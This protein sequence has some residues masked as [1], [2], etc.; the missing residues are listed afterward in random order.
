MTDA[1]ALVAVRATLAV[2]ARLAASTRSPADDLLVQMLQANES[3]LT[4]AVFE[5]SQS[6][7][8]LTP[9]RVAKALDGVGIHVK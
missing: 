1:D 6:A 5:L 2:M 4:R 9:E 3:R 7:D 8:A